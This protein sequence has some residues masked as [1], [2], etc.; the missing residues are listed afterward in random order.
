MEFEKFIPQCHRINDLIIWRISWWSWICSLCTSTFKSSSSISLRE[1]KQNVNEFPVCDHLPLIFLSTSS[2]KIISLLFHIYTYED[3]REMCSVHLV[4][5]RPLDKSYSF[6]KE[7]RQENNYKR[8]KY[9]ISRKFCDL[10]FKT[11]Q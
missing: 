1:R 6:V 11:H 10:D 8:K 5:A 9:L 4:Y 2:V 7:Q 3:I